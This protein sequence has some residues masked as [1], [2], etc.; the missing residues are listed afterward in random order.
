MSADLI[1]ETRDL[2]K[3]FEPQGGGD[4][5][6][7]VKG[8]SLEMRRGEIFGLL[9]PN[10]AGKTTTISIITT[11]YLP[12]SGSVLV[13]GID[14]ANRPADAK[15]RIGVAPQLP[16]LDN[17]LTVWEILYTHGRYFG[18]PARES[19]RRTRNLLERFALTDKAKTMPRELS[20]GMVRR[21]LLARALVHEPELLLLD[22][23][24]VGIDPQTRRS[25]WDEIER[26]RND[27]TSIL[28]TTH[29]IEEAD[30]LCDRVA[31]V[32]HGEVL[33]IDE[34]NNLKMLV[35]AGTR[36]ELA[37]DAD[38]AQDALAAAKALDMVEVVEAT[39]SG[40]RVYAT[41]GEAMVPDIVGAVIDAK[42]RLHHVAVFEPSLEDV[43]IHFTGR[44]L[45]E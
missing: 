11:R 4:P 12:T 1:L 33:A 37:I 24:T 29:Y 25:M 34:P 40:L 36:V 28:I 7:A 9:G 45:R 13:D 44:D 6:E 23:A 43:F 8:I 15:R 20:G 5:V 2:R 10:G 39:D 21:L 16:N 30:Q 42:A 3:T 32:D 35:P 22:E 38:G 31:I 26:L 19:R 18:L 17:S 27:G 14:V 41:G